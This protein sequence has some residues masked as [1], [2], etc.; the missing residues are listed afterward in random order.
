MAGHCMIDA[1]DEARAASAGDIREMRASRVLI[2]VGLAVFLGCLF[3]LTASQ[4]RF[5]YE[6]EAIDQTEAW[7]SGMLGSR[8][9]LGGILPFSKSGFIEV[10]AYAP[11]AAV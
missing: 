9:E 5:G 2:V 6:G 10:I 11:F 3:G 7:L 8:P 1:V 4:L